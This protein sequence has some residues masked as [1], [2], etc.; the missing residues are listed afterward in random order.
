ML[1]REEKPTSGE[2]VIG[3]VRVEK[4][5]NRIREEE[6]SI[7][8]ET[9]IEELR[10]KSIALSFVLQ[11]YVYSLPLDLLFINSHEKGKMDFS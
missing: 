8:C 6:I 4:L 11:G 1:Y 3:G 9:N 2:I 10:M 7:L 5:K